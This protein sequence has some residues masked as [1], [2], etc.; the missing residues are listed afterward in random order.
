MTDMG[1][2]PNATSGNPGHTYRFYTGTPIYPFGTGL[3]C[4]KVVPTA[5]GMLRLC[6]WVCTQCRAVPFRVWDQTNGKRVCCTCV[7]V[8]VGGALD[9][10]V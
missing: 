1:M 4:V 6:V 3:R 9:P 8:F 10:S 7:C 2:R 5:G